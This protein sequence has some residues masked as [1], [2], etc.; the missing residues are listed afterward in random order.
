MHRIRCRRQGGFSLLEV[1]VTMFLVMIGLLVVM[2]SFVAIAKSTKYSA[3]M[4][5]ANTLAR[6]EMEKVRNLPFANI[7]SAT[8]AYSEYPDHPDYRHEVVVQ[9]VGSSRQVTVRIYFENDRRRAEL[10]TYVTNLE[11]YDAWMRREL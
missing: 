2:S 8:G 7:Q 3:R 9:D 1:M 10:R 4:D 11:R 5:V 6:L